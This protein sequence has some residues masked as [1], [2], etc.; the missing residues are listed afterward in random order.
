MCKL[1][2]TPTEDRK[3]WNLRI[4]YDEKR[5]EEKRATRELCTVNSRKR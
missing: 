5:K 1:K 2:V 4:R 3:G